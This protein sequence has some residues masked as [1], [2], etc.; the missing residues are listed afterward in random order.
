MKNFKII[1][2]TLAITNIILAI[3]ILI[4]ASFWVMMAFIGY[5]ITQIIIGFY[6]NKITK[7]INDKL[8]VNQKSE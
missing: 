8:Y 6:Q 3:L 5:I 4:F 1:I 7:Y 2:G